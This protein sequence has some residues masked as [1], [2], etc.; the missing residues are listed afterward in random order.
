MGDVRW[1]SQGVLGM[2]ADTESE[3]GVRHHTDNGKCDARRR[4]GT[5]GREIGVHGAGT[6]GLGLP[7]IC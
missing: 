2:Q 7:V 4:K 1:R 6:D 3:W 5:G